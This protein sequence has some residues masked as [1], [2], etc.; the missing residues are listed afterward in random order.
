M[1]EVSIDGVLFEWPETK[2]GSNASLFCPNN[3]V[4]TISRHCFDDG[5]WG[6]FDKERCGQLAFTFEV[7]EKISQNVMNELPYD[8]S[9][10]VLFLHCS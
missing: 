2:S 4:F 9:L 10:T 3:P 7:I 5:Q 1:E 8:I 6:E